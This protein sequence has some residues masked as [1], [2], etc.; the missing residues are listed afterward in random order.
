VLLE[1][2][3]A[4]TVE[5]DRPAAYR[6]AAGTVSPFHPRPGNPHRGP[7]VLSVPDIVRPERKQLMDPVT[8]VKAQDEER[9][10]AGGE[11]PGGREDGF[12]LGW[13]QGISSGHAAKLGANEPGRVHWLSGQHRECA[14]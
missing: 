3:H 9:A 5:R 14:R 11:E 13:G 1:D 10:I 6:M 8:G 4:R 7:G 12:K 2:A